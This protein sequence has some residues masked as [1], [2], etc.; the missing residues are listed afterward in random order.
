MSKP[1]HI[2]IPQ[3]LYYSITIIKMIIMGKIITVRKS[4]N[5]YIL[6][7]PKGYCEMVNIKEGSKIDIEPFTKD[8]LMLK[9]I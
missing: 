4:G 1:K 2:I 3:Y 6:T 9:V 8:S 7:L 5:S